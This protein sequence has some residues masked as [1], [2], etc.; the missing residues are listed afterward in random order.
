MK[1]LIILLFLIVNGFLYA[2]NVEFTKDNFKDK[3][4]EL[5][6]ALRYVAAGDELFNKGA[7]SY[8]LALSSYLMADKFNSNNAQLN[9]KIGICYL[10]STNKTKAASYLEKAAKL[11]PSLSNE[12][13]FWL[14]K[15][16]HLQS[17]WDKAIIE[18]RT[19]QK[20]TYNPAKF[21][22]KIDAASKEIE[23]CNT[24]LELQ[25]KPLRVFIENVGDAINSPFPDYAAVI[26]AD[27]DRMIFTSSRPTAAGAK[28]DN[29]TNDYY[30]ELYFSFFKNGKWAPAQ[31]IGKPINTDEN[32][33]TLGLSADGQKLLMCSSKSSGDI[34]ESE[35]NGQ[36]WTKPE[37]LN[38][39]INTEFKES[40]ACYTADGKTIYFV[41]DRPGGYGGK[42]I[43]YCKKDEKGK[44]G[45]AENIGETINT[46]YNE[47]GVYMHPDGKTLYF[48]SEGHKGIGGYDIYKSVFEAGAWQKPE[49]I[50]FP[51]NSAD[52][53]VFFVLSANGKHGY[54]SS[55]NSEL[56][57]GEKDIYKITFLG[58]EKPMVLSNEDNL[59]GSLSTPVKENILAPTIMIK[60]SQLTL[61]NGIIVDEKTSLPIE[62]TIEIRDNAKNQLIAT[63]VSNASTG[64]YLIALP[65][66]KNYA[67]AVIKENYLF[68][69]EN[70]DNTESSSYKEVTKN[71]SLK[72]ITVGSK[73]ILKNIFFDFGKATLKPESSSELER[74]KKLLKEESSIKIEISGHTDNKG[75][76]EYNQKLSENRAKAVADYLIAGGIKKERMTIIGYGKQQPIASNDKEEGRKQNN[77]IEYKITSK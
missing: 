71:I 39:N 44:W 2:Q 19:F 41:S 65:V 20:L 38:K 1:K 28:K 10:Y 47:E 34:Y 8:K 57:Y 26:S 11:N 60:E 54:Y 22:E 21:K 46:N 35:L 69:S 45:K 74:L 3:G 16:Y 31:N 61:I 40:S 77:R 55:V 67:I 49:N 51:V 37:K 53:D 13:H 52:D 68:Y 62:A 66:G 50:G 58:P 24:A 27:E 14:G 73:T 25:K 5:K 15:A 23:E 29:S 59:I 17:E 9:Y 12:V 33:S 48:S 72:G 30:E 42:D 32:Q 43:Y 64:R 18:F 75:S 56:G 4:S 6:E 70:V 63:F 7:N 36:T 76:A